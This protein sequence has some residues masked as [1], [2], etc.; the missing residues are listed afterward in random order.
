MTKKSLHGSTNLFDLCQL[1][2]AETYA[3]IFEGALFSSD[4]LA[5]NLV[6]CKGVAGAAILLSFNFILN[7]LKLD[8]PTSYIRSVFGAQVIRTS[9]FASSSRVATNVEVWALDAPLHSAPAPGIAA[10]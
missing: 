10:F 7:L 4:M 8:I 5:M 6:I 3:A 2:I 1:L 9:L